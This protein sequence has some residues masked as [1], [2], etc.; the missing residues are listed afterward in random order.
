MG[1]APKA[2]GRGNDSGIQMGIGKQRATKMTA[3]RPHQSTPKPA[4]KRGT[5]T[6][7]H[8]HIYS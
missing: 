1:T 7:H 3:K 2:A 4:H 6:A 8:L 5:K